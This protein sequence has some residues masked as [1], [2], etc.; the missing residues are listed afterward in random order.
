MVMNDN[1]A[2]FGAIRYEMNI[3]W[4]IEFM[5][6]HGYVYRK[7][8]P[9]YEDDDFWV[10]METLI[11]DA[12]NA[13]PFEFMNNV[14]ETIWDML[15]GDAENWAKV[16]CYFDVREE[17]E[18]AE[19]L[20]TALENEDVG[21]IINLEDIEVYDME[22]IRDDMLGVKSLEDK[23]TLRDNLPQWFMDSYVGLICEAN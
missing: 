9:L 13:D 5:E 22:V 3:Q 14:D 15:N 12:I 4:F 19:K 1:Y 23:A 18:Y 11:E 21:T 10:D 8:L 7:A 16:E 20:L 2:G 6:E 17:A